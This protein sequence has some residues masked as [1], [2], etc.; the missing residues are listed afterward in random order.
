LPSI[1]LRQLVNT[2]YHFRCFLR[3][4]RIQEFPHPSTFSH[5][6]SDFGNKKFLPL[7]LNANGFRH[8]LSNIM[9]IDRYR[10]FY[11]VFAIRKQS[12]SMSTH[13]I[14]GSK[15]YKLH[16]CTT[17]EAMILSH[18]FTIANRNDTVL[19]PA[20]LSS[21]QHGISSLRLVMQRMTAKISGKWRNKQESFLLL[22]LI[23]AIV[24]NE[25]IPMVGL[26]LSS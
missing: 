12:G 25:K 17:T 3:A 1:R 6:V 22:R 5:T 15:R 23:V 13:N 11:P 21:L 8:S 10:P 20:L 24:M 7:T 19:A 9:I 18:V 2:L 16:L 26:F 14:T 4:C